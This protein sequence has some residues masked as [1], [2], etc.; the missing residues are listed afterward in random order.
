MDIKNE[1]I[2]PL[3]IQIEDT[4][5]TGIVYHS[6]YLKFME[7]ARSEWLEQMDCGMQWQRE[8]QIM[9]VVYS[10][11]QVFL[12]PAYVH[13]QVEV[14]TKIISMSPASITFDQHLRLANTTDKILCK[15][16]IKIAC[17]N[18]D[19]RPRTLPESTLLTTIRRILT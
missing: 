2:Y 16:E 6:N 4:D 5:F 13:D 12:K 14:V 17:I 8:H 3:K 10:A 11:N 1:F 9:F 15:A 19:L 18:P 7:R